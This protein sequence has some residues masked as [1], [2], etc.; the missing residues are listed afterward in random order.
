MTRKIRTGCFW[1]HS[2]IRLTFS[3]PSTNIKRPDIRKRIPKANIIQGLLH[4]GSRYEEKNTTASVSLITPAKYIRLPFL[5]NSNS[6]FIM[7]V[8]SKYTIPIIQKNMPKLLIT[9]SIILSFHLDSR[10]K[11]FSNGSPSNTVIFEPCIFNYVRVVEVSAVE[12]N[13]FFK[14]CCDKP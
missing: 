6:H 12:D 2:S 11:T 7:S 4:S 1:Y 8:L 10:H 9:M 14:L 3:G 5:K 13:G